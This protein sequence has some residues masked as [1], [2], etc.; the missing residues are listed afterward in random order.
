MVWQ[1]QHEG[2]AGGINPVV[3]PPLP[4]RDVAI[5][6]ECKTVI[7]AARLEAPKMRASSGAL[8]ALRLFYMASL[9][10]E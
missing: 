8:L 9:V 4:L 3:C 1:W 5:A 2:M 6:G 10:M 7:P